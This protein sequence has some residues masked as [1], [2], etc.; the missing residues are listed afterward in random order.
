MINRRLLQAMLATAVFAGSVNIVSAAAAPKKASRTASTTALKTV[1]LCACAAAASA[2]ADK[3]EIPGYDCE[4]GGSGDQL[5]CTKIPTETELFDTAMQI[6]N[7][8]V[9][10]EEDYKDFSL[11]TDKIYYGSMEEKGEGELTRDIKVACRDSYMPDCRDSYCVDSRNQ[12]RLLCVYVKKNRAFKAHQE[13][14]KG[15]MNK[16]HA[17]I[18]RSTKA[19]SKR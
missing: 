10:F 14:F 9:A 11:E 15:R 3:P 16:L 7:D 4:T 17:D 18:K 12:Q 13:E 1:L 8:T 6:L 19:R 2:T 5:V